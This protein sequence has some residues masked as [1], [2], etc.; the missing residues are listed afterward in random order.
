VSRERRDE[1]YAAA[2]VENGQELLH[3][4]IGSA[5]VDGELIVE[6]LDG[7]VFDRCRLQDS[8]IGHNNIKPFAN[9]I[10]NSGSKRMRTLGIG[11]IRSD[12]IGMAAGR[13]D[14]IDNRLGCIGAMAVVYD[15]ASAGGSECQSYGASD[16]AR[17][18]SDECGSICK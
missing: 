18:A 14:L 16:A 12:D 2:T 6:V 8:R 4:E 1:H 3:K 7:H 15:D 10:A 13:A 5:N 11:E 17:G 9:E